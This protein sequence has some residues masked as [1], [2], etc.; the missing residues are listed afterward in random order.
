ML[1]PRA[2]KKSGNWHWGTVDAADRFIARRHRGEAEK[3]WQHR[4]EQ[5]PRETG[6]AG[7]GGAAVLIQR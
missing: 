6:G 2:A 3:S 1:W 5:Q 4:Q 7:G